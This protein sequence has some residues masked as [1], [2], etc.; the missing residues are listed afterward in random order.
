MLSAFMTL[1]TLYRSCQEKRRCDIPKDEMASYQGRE[2][3]PQHP[4]YSTLAR[5]NGEVNELPIEEVKKR[6]TGR[7]LSDMYVRSSGLS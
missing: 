5:V 6:L 4:L 7:E 3:A 1:T 2:G